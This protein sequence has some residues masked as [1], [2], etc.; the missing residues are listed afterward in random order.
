[1]DIPD[2]V[3]NPVL[4]R[5]A[6]T[7]ADVKYAR[8]GLYRSAWMVKRYTELGGKYSGKPSSQGIKR[9]LDKEEWISVIPYLRDR[10]IVKCGSADGE[11]IA[12]RPMVRANDKTP[13]TLPELLK[14]H[15]KDKLL[16][17]AGEKDKNPAKRI[18]W[19]AGTIS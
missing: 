7:E 4:Y 8:A 6:K 2:N 14:I 5:K 1:M 11:L 17:L 9:W 13:I 3:L 19:K 10:K 15:T 16:K 12:C 18:N